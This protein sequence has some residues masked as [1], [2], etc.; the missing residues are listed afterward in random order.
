MIKKLDVRNARIYIEKL[1]PEFNLFRFSICPTDGTLGYA[2]LADYTSHKQ[3]LEAAIDKYA[4]I[5][6]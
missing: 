2:S 4:E 5:M 6:K 1:D 3:A